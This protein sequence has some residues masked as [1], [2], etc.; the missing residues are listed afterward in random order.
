MAKLSLYDGSSGE[1]SKRESACGLTVAIVDLSGTTRNWFHL[2]ST[3]DHWRLKFWVKNLAVLE[4]IKFRGTLM[5]QFQ[6]ECEQQAS[7]DQDANKDLPLLPS[8]EHIRTE[9]EKLLTEFAANPVPDLAS[10]CAGRHAS[11][12]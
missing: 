8:T 10:L 12:E 5:R 9:A 7:N 11:S 2:S 6:E 4:S 3:S 1:E